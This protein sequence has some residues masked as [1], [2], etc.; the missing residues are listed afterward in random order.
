MNKRHVVLV[1]VFLILIVST[2]FSFDAAKATKAFKAYVEDFKK[3]ESQLPVISRL[4]EDLE[5]LALYRLYKLQIAGSVEKKE[6]TTTIPDLLTDHM[7]SLGEGYF[8]SEEEKIA[9][10]AFLSWIATDVSGKKFQVG[11]INEMPAYSLTFNSYS[12]RIRAA[13]PRVYESWIAYSLGLLK[14]RPESFPEGKLP[15]PNTFN[16]FDL[17]VTIDRSEQE[18]IASITD[19]EI[20][21]QLSKSIQGISNKKYDVSKLFND[22]VDERVN[23]IS[24][25]LP[26]TL[27]GLEDSTKNLL[28][29]WIYR[30][31]SLI[32]EAPFYPDS[33]PISEINIPGFVNSV[34]LEDP[35]Y[36][37]ISSIIV[38]DNLIMMQLNFALKM[39]GNNVYSPIGLIEADIANEAKKMVA[40]L[41]STLGQI[42][43]NLSGEF[44]ASVSAKP[45]FGWMRIFAYVLIV[46]L[47][48]TYMKILKKYLLYIIV[49][50]E[51]LYLL[52][53][54]NPNQNA[55]DL[56][57]YA[58]TII[59]LL[60]F[61]TLITL[62]RVLSKKRRV[63]D[64]LALAL[65][66]LA[67]L[68]P[69]VKLYRNVPE[70]S[71]EKFPEF[72]NS[73]YYDKLKND[74]FESPDSLFNIE[75]RKLTSLISSELNDLKR[76]YR[77]VIPNML[78][79]L[80]K[81]TGTTFS[82]SGTRLR[83]SMPSF[84][85]YLSIENEPEYISQ[86]EDLQ[87][88]FKSFVRNSK[89]NYSQYRRV[90]GNIENM[91]EKIVIYAGNPLREDFEKYLVKTLGNK[92]EYMVAVDNIEKA[93]SDEMKTEP[94]SASISPYKIPK[95]TY[96]LLG[97]FLLVATTIIF[98]NFVLSMLEGILLV[99]AFIGTMGTKTLDIF[100]QAGTPHL[101]LSVNSGISIWFFVLFAVIIVLAEIFAFISYRKGRESA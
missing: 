29:L 61:A 89:R 71:M 64:L 74:L 39:I 19:E 37:K 5:D 81:N 24:G 47:S 30:A 70:L 9:Y 93:I 42:R 73:I 57:L 13:A 16:E 36:E 68:L 18:E 84:A 46:F 14:E 33:I 101:K 10:S 92:Q 75:V 91:A 23:F 3:E 1:L 86:F 77:V 4:K 83:L 26:D 31:F 51:T 63:F 52:F 82:V 78:N 56:S 80:A 27:A 6:S 94:V 48:F 60:V 90:L 11:T 38:N 96:I 100:V 25:R 40:P 8:S 21:K 67:L 69:F 99:I 49:G 85:D 88:S 7:K 12:S 87:K 28:R 59:P 50:F 22:K 54:S 20:L 62:G 72:Y 97:I 17:S 98:K 58:I 44:V 76:G 43:N 55:F 95:Y 35:N 34:P 65:I 53:L 79:D 2:T 32:D 45:S 66:L 15:I 41:L